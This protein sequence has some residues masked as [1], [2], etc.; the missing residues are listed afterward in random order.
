VNLLDRLLRSIQLL[1]LAGMIAAFS[2]IATAAAGVIA[3]SQSPT[4][5]TPFVALFCLLCAVLGGDGHG[6]P[7]HSGHRLGPE[8]LR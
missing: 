5:P 3:G 6:P 8:A 1:A 4:I 2:M 7:P